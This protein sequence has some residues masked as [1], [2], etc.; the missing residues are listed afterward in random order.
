MGHDEHFSI[1]KVMLRRRTANCLIG[2]I[3]IKPGKTSLQYRKAAFHLSV[4][5]RHVKMEADQVSFAENAG[6]LGQQ[7]SQLFGCGRLQE[8]GGNLGNVAQDGIDGLKRIFV[9]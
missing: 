5:N 6:Q 4:E 1:D 9:H 3:S 8:S 7:A 2:L